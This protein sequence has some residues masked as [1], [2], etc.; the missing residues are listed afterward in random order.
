M[1]FRL[2]EINMLRV[3]HSYSLRLP[4]P[5][6]K[7][8]SIIEGNDCTFVSDLTKVKLQENSDSLGEWVSHSDFTVLF[9]PK[10]PSNTV[11]PSLCFFSRTF[12][13]GIL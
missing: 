7:D 3:E 2:Q 9:S 5:G 6:P 11:T 13:A 4:L 1:V 10:F 8:K 12:T